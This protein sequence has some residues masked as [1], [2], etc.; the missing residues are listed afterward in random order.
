MLPTR[1]QLDDVIFHG[2]RAELID[3]YN[4]FIRTIKQIYDTIEAYYADMK[5]LQLP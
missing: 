1:K 5:Y 3:Q 4:T 2:H